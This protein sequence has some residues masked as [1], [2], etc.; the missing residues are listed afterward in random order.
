LAIKACYKTFGDKIPQAVVFDTSFH[1]T[2][3]EEVYM[4]ALPY[5]YYEKYG[6]RKYGAHGTSH[7]FVS[8]RVAEINGENAKDVRR[9][10][11]RAA[12]I[13]FAESSALPKAP[14]PPKS[15]FGKIASMLAIAGAAVAIPFTAGLSGLTLIG[16]TVA[17]T[18][19]VATGAVAAGAAGVA[20]IGLLGNVG[21]KSQ[22][23]EHNIKTQLTGSKSTDNFNYQETLTSEY[24]WETLECKTCIRARGCKKIK[25][26]LFGDK[27]C[28]EW[29]AE[30][31]TC[32]TTQF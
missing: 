17:L 27:Y 19:T 25:N 11:G 18:S 10:M 21:N 28:K 30:T 4:F 20:G 7:K 12:C 9:E 2:M 8:E 24:N 5:E 16:G 23:V 15:A 6:I 22:A 32:R 26:P 14:K 29:N 13:D 31:N 3:S 1:Q